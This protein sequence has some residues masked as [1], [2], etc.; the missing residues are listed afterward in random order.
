ML[1]IENL[2]SLNAATYKVEYAVHFVLLDDMLLVAKRR[3]RRTGEGG[4]LVAERCWG[5]SEIS[6]VDVKDST[7]AQYRFLAS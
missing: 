5:L 3:K 4:K 6:V 7:G 1:E 2:W